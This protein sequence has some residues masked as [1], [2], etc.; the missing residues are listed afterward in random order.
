MTVQPL[1]K[2]EQLVEAIR[3]LVAALGADTLVDLMQTKRD[4]LHELSVDGSR[5]H[6]PAPAAQS[7][8]VFDY[9]VLI[10]LLGRRDAPPSLVGA[11][12]NP[13]GELVFFRLEGNKF[14]PAATQA[15]VQAASGRD[16]FGALLSLRDDAGNI[17]ALK[18][19]LKNIEDDEVIT[20]IELRAADDSPLALAPPQPP[21]RQSRRPAP[22]AAK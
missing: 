21:V 11:G 19:R 3:E 10:G 2:T 8:V 14:L 13:E 5:P 6:V 18:M 20:R 15:W 1:D 9:A 22:V 7:R 4:L 16:E 17:V 12:R